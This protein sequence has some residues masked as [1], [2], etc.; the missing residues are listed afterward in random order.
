MARPQNADAPATRARIL[1]AATRLIAA[2]GYAGASMRDIAADAGIT[3]AALYHH[4]PGKEDILLAVLDNMRVQLLTGLQGAFQ[5]APPGEDARA[6][7]LRVVRTMLQVM[8]TPAQRLSFRI[9]VT[10]GGRLPLDAVRQ[11]LETQRT[12]VAMLMQQLMHMG[13][14]RETLPELAVYSFVGPIMMYRVARQLLNMAPT[15]ALDPD[16]FSAGHVDAFLRAYGAQPPA[17][18]FPAP[19]PKPS[20]RAVRRKGRP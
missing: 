5:S 7:L 1:D 2:H 4:F 18:A 8:E 3:G 14:L 10:E 16:V 12:G 11:M 15:G 19:S 9:M 17:P 20:Q 6:L 13:L